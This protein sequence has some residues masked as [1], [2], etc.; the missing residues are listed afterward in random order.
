MVDGVEGLEAIIGYHFK[1]SQLLLDALTH[2]SLANQSGLDSYE[3]LEF[4]GDSVLNLLVSSSLY[5]ILDD[6]PPGELT[7]YKSYPVSR[8][9]LSKLAV[10]IGI[11]KYLRVPEG[12]Q[13]ESLI[14]N[15]SVLEDVM[16]AIFG[17]VYVDGGLKG[18]RGVFQKI[19]WKPMVE[20][21]DD[22]G[23]EV[24]YKAKLQTY[25]L[26]KYGKLPKY[27]VVSVSGPRHM[28]KFK[29]SVKIN[30]EVVGVGIGRSKKIG[31]QNA[32]K[33]GCKRVGVI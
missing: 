33:D 29:I 24:N 25:S 21:I 32:A 15:A 18:A 10:Q 26:R 2:S 17:A 14:N 16:E 1:D 11:V 3:R 4:L 28:Q 23:M 12:I 27:S 31:E 30:G 8:T 5:L 9:F 20:I 13:G 22:N 7:R 6:A 19:F